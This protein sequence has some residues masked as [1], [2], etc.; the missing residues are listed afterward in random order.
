MASLFWQKQSVRPWLRARARG[1][2][3]ASGPLLALALASE[4]RYSSG[5][6]DPLQSLGTILKKALEDL[7]NILW[8]PC[9]ACKGLNEGL[10]G[11]PK[12]LKGPHEYPKGSL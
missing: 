1:G 4:S 6:L 8:G 10:K 7:T 12:A 3:A 9:K 5:A 2:P 11:L